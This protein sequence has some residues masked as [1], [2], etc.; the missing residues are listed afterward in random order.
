MAEPVT[1]GAIAATDPVR[2]PG[3]HPAEADVVVIGG[4][5]CGIATALYLARAGVRVVVCE[6]G[7]VAG[8]QSSRNWGWVRAQGRDRAELPIM[9]ESQR[10]WAE[11]NALAPAMIGLRQTGVC[12]LAEDERTLASFQDWM[13]LARS[14]RT[15]T[16]MLTRTEIDALYPGHRGHWLGGMRTDADMRAEPFTAV[17][18]IA[19][20]AAGAGATI[21][22]NCAVRGLDIQAGRVAGVVTERGRI[23]A[24]QVLLAGGAWSGLFARHAGQGFPHL[25]VRATVLRTN[26]LP[27][28]EAGA[29]LS[30]DVAW[31]RREDGGYTLAPNT[32]NDF[33]IGP[34]AFRHLAAFVP[35]MR[36]GDLKDTRL[37]PAAP[38]GF[39]DG[40]LTP[41]KW[42]PDQVSPFER[43]RVLDPAPNMA[44]A[45]GSLSTFARLF[46]DLPAPR[47]V[48]AWAG[49]IDTTSDQVPVM[50]ETGLPGFWV[51]TGQSGHGFGIGP[52]CGRV[53][54]D[55]MRGRDPGHDM[56]RFRFSR[57]SD[58]SVPELGPA[59]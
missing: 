59:V 38:A 44:L 43:M 53:M 48:H 12:Y 34:D 32:A 36:R 51:M 9:L 41:R 18:A 47:I 52:G 8:E 30:R 40:W 56:A 37:R 46:P 50:D 55:M 21:V 17:A 20:I 22:E 28:I 16:R 57:F 27:L 35:M 45:R 15:G 5:I 24:P 26:E 2:F 31:R 29:A 1:G 33:W 7:R 25:S 42:S 13:P 4:G 19:R 58:G 14:R 3:P 54:A 10:L 6:K 11:L 49:M 39:P 23:R